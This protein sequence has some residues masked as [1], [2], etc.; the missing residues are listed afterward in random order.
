MIDLTAHHRLGSYPI[1]F[2]SL[3]ETIEGLPE[4]RMIVTDQNVEVH[5]GS[6]WAKDDRVL[7]VPA[8]EPSKSVQ[9]WSALQ[10]GLSRLG[11]NRLTTL[12]AFGGGVVGDLAGF[13]AA[14]YMRGIPLIQVP[15]SLL[16]QVDSSVGGKV[17][18]DIPEGKNLVGAFYP[19]VAVDI[20]VESLATLPER[21]YRNGMAEVWKYGFI[22]DAALV[23]RLER[24][25]IG[26][27]ETIRRCVE[28]KRDVVEADEF[29]TTGERAKLNFGHTVGHAIE[30]VAGYGTILH[31]EA[32]SVGMVVEAA[33]GEA[34]GLT[35]KGVRETVCQ[36]LDSAGLPTTSVVLRDI[37][38][39]IAS[40]RRDKKASAGKFAFS[41]LTKIG[42]CVLCPDVP[43]SDIRAILA[44]V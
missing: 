2:R 44:D 16:A 19:P 8:G 14:T 36:C 34:I 32:I 21:E 5:Y 29:E 9:Q 37:E 40:M 43:E 7:S 13:V 20:C 39:L 23:D 11:A 42:D 41:L 17:G 24:K 38:M 33:L 25:E 27:T 31:G 15:T 4:N 1:R 10:S 18:I 3:R 30:A 28:L 26:T 35:A 12:V 6:L 22:L